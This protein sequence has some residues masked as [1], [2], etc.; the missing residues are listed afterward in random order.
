MY[1]K[2]PLS[3]HSV[4]AWRKDKNIKPHLIVGPVT[5]TTDTT[6]TIHNNAGESMDTKF[7]LNKTE[8]NFQFLHYTVDSIK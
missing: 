3:G 6:I 1:Y 7:I 4:A 8:W 2:E 5:E